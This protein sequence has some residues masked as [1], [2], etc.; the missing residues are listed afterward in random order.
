MRGIQISC[1]FL[2]M[3]LAA[4]TFFL[5]VVAKVTGEFPILLNQLS[6]VDLHVIL[7]GKPLVS[8]SGETLSY[9]KT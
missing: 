4:V 8:F 2:N 5:T 7:A 6:G 3:A 9:L 1:V